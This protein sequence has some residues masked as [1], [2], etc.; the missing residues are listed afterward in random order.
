MN[1]MLLVREIIG[2]YTVNYMELI[3]VLCYDIHSGYV[4]SVNTVENLLVNLEVHTPLVAEYRVLGKNEKEG[5]VNKH[6]RFP[7]LPPLL[8]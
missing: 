8:A 5:L 4:Y 7:Q 6:L 3:N 2:I 1:W